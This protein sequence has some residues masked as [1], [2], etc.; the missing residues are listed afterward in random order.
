LPTSVSYRGALAVAFLVVW[1][2]LAVDPADRAHWAAENLIVLAFSVALWLIRDRVAFSRFSMAAIF[3]FLCLHE[4]GA[5]HGYAQVPY[6]AWL[7]RLTGTTLEATLGVE[8]NHYDRLVHLAFGVLLSWPIREFLVQTSAVR[9]RWSY[10]LPVGL[11][12]ASA[13]AYEVAE[14]LAVALVAQAGEGADLLGMQGDVWDAQKDMALAAGGSMLAMTV[15]VNLRPERARR[16][17]P[18][19]ALAGTSDQAASA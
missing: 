5:H 15:A 17:Q 13:M 1:L 8:R 12:M 19:S 9:G 4:V 6:E 3:A 18:R 16:Q 14:W 7:E 11:V 2:L 10:L